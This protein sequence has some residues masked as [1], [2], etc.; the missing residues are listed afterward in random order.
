MIQKNILSLVVLA[1]E[2]ALS[3]GF[4][5]PQT[6]E[7]PVELPSWQIL[8]ERISETSPGAQMTQWSGAVSAELGFSDVTS[9]MARAPNFHAGSGG[10][11]SFGD[12]LQM[13]GIGNTPY[14][15][16][17]GVLVSVDGA[18]AGDTFANGL[19]WGEIER[20]EIFRGPQPT[21]FGRNAPAGVINIILRRPDNHSHT[22]ASVSYGRFDTFSA[23][24]AV[25]APIR[26]DTLFA[27]ASFRYT[28]EDGFLENS[29]LGRTV[30][31]RELSAGQVHLRWL[32]APDWEISFLAALQ[33]TDDGSQRIT[34]FSR[35]WNTE[36][37]DL[38][39]ESQSRR[40][41]QLLKVV[42]NGEDFRLSLLTSRYGWS[43][44]P[45]VID[46]DFSPSPAVASRLWQIQDQWSQEIR[47][48]S[49]VADRP[50]HWKLGGLL[51]NAATQGA[52][53][54]T[55]AYPLPDGSIFKT[56]VDTR[57]SIGEE[58]LAFY[59]QLNYHL[60]SSWQAS[61]SLRWDQ[62]QKRLQRSTQS[63]ST[64][65]QSIDQ[66]RQ[67][68]KYSPALGLVWKPSGQFQLFARYVQTFQP[69][70]FSA[71]TS[72]AS[73]RVFRPATIRANEIGG[74]WE[75]IPGKWRIETTAFWYRFRDYQVERSLTPNDYVVVNA[76]RAESRG[77][78]VEMLAIPYRGLELSLGWGLLDTAFKDYRDPL[79]QTDFSGKKV[80]YA[81]DFTLS[82][83][84][85]YAVPEGPLAGLKA[86][87]AYR[88]LGTT[89]FSEA[90]AAPFLDGGYG[91]LEARLSYAWKEWEFALFGKNLTDD[92]HY[93]FILPELNGGVP[94][95]PRTYGVSV[96]W[97]F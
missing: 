91:L 4:A 32:P 41:S 13:R 38:P 72:N 86:R 57:H 73:L 6:T 50:W 58:G 80:P 74:T 45:L 69:G 30:D 16:S 62:V 31:R 48:E 78:E 22:R 61:A 53:Y 51:Y 35:P 34:Q 64:P 3:I 21:F 8:T 66:N 46:Y 26:Q 15:S 76:S 75:I 83:A 10:L 9:L 40:D 19:W 39:G 97:K 70:G 63:A 65:K 28:K 7:T 37:S 95:Q 55:V 88:L 85:A 47:L 68:S 82:L 77:V 29:T 11:R 94:G 36:A 12:I 89:Y 43:L 84:A 71:Y 60:T 87:L 27:G 42:H 93:E 5:Q 56:F 25:L 44:D 20:V 54:R 33:M 90:N 49:M 59:G 14:F 18:L 52:F 23:Q 17:P 1:A 67:D 79:Q 24:A 81:P 96:E 92:R 2:L